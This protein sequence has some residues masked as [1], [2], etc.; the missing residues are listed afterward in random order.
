MP[1]SFLLPKEK[2]VAA[3]LQPLHGPL[4]PGDV[5][6]LARHTP[7]PL[8]PLFLSWLEPG[9][10]V[11]W[12]GGVGGCRLPPPERPQ[13][14]FLGMHTSTWWLSLAHPRTLS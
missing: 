14:A 7:T 1:L 13:S 9:W 6:R 2:N 4:P 11:R 5:R 12:Y 8:S 3:A 10:S